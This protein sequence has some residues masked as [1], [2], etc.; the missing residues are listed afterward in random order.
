MRVGC[1]IFIE[2]VEDENGLFRPQTRVVC[3]QCG[4]E[5]TSWGDSEAS[6]KRCFAILREEC[7]NEEYNF[8]EEE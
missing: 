6:G 2:E 8:Y 4:H 5:A 3:S 1:E 7:P